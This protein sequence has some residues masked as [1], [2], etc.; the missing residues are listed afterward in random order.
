MRAV[1]GP[2]EPQ[3]GAKLESRPRP[4]WSRAFAPSCVRDSTPASACAASP[5]VSS[6][7]TAL[8]NKRVPGFLFPLLQGSSARPRELSVDAQ[9]C[10]AGAGRLALKG[11]PPGQ[12]LG[13]GCGK[14]SGSGFRGAPQA[15]P[16]NMCL[17]VS[18]A[19][20]V[21]GGVSQCP[22]TRTPNKA[23]ATRSWA[24]DPW[25]THRVPPL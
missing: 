25:Q 23:R 18:I 1:L 22:P 4:P 13:L 21:F 8:W 9:G 7:S 14:D 20:L 24:R 12:E 16:A 10:G 17:F 3:G 5:R 11:P 15:G 6:H 19:S 2:E